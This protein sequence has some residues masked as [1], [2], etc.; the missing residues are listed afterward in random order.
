MEDPDDGENLDLWDL[1]NHYDELYF[2]GALDAA[3]FA[4]EWAYPRTKN[5]TCFGSCSFGDLRKIT[6]YEPILQYRTNADLKNALLHLMIHAIIFV[7]HGM[8]RL[9]HGPVFRD[10]MD[11]INTCTTEDYMRPP[12]GYCITTTHD[13]SE[14]KSCNIQGIQW[15]CELCG[16]TLLRATR[17]APPSDSSCCIE[18]VS[19]HV[20]C[21]NMLCQ[22]HNHKMGCG[23]TYVVT[24][25]P[26]Q[27]MVPKGTQLLLL[28]GPTEMTKSQGAVQQSDSDSDEM[29]KTIVLCAAPRSRRRLKPKQEFVAWDNIEL[30]PTVSRSNVKSV[31]CSSSKKA[32]D[33][34]LSKLKWKQTSVTSLGSCENAKSSG[35]NTSRKAGKLKLEQEDVKSS[36]PLKKLKLV[37]DLAAS[38]KYGAFSLG[39]CNAKPPGSSTSR[40][41]GCNAKPP[42]SSTSRNAGKWRNSEGVEKS[43]VPR[44]TAFPQKTKLVTFEKRGAAK[45]SKTIT[46]DKVGKLHTSDVIENSSV[47]PSTPP[48]KLK[49]GK[50]FVALEKHGVATSGSITTDKVSKLHKP[51]GI[52]KA[53]GLP[54]APLAKLKPDLVASEKNVDCGNAKVPDNISSKMA[55][56]EHEHGGSQKHISLHVAPQTTL[57]QPDETSSRLKARKQHKPEDFPKVSVKPAVPQSKLKQSNRA[58]LERQ[59]TRSKT[60]S[61]ARKKEYVCFSLWQNFYESECSSGSAESLVNK[62]SVRRKRQRQRTVQITYSRSRKRSASEVSSELAKPPS[63]HL[64]VI[65]IDDE[66]MTEDPR[67]EW[68]PPAPCMDGGTVKPTDKVMTEAPRGQSKPPTPSKDLAAAAPPADQVM[69]EA[70]RG[71]S[72]PPAPPKDVPAVPTAD[73]M[74]T[75]A[76][77]GLSKQPAPSMDIAAFSPADQVTTQA[78]RGQSQPPAQRMDIAIPPADQVM[79]Q[80]PVGQSQPPAPNMDIAALSPADQVMTQAP[81][82][83][84]QPLAQRMD[85]AIPPADVPPADQVMTQAPVDQSQPPAPCSIAADQVVPPHSADPPG[86]APSNPTS[87]PDVIDI[88][89]DD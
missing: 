62:R 39:S 31:G 1:F 87:C 54:A 49:L 35:S 2:R 30:L 71:Q 21:G 69:A 24:K 86:L 34:L 66:V 40:N 20:T 79:T 60:K 50:D 37:Q 23:G 29:Q 76:P 22:W 3:A 63:Q 25:P 67:G 64:E 85:I 48:K 45:L 77:R 81:R 72:K 68:K 89:D 36:A 44:P 55:H 13:F 59:T 19:E 42:G 6:L 28:T 74:M 51:E 70:P 8:K 10:W 82:G 16:V 65:V 57:K 75:D 73:Q 47:L 12:G 26:G 15:K 56:K 84:S 32:E 4:V 9:S 52:Q 46:P 83:Q 33:V 53:C 78:P 18:N 88:S 43:I 80:A 41:A 17:M 14:E 58:A 5:I 7:K 27:R 11:A 61:S 38:E